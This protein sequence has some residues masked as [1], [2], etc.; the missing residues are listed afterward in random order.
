MKM[1][2]LVALAL[3]LLVALSGLAWRRIKGKAKGVDLVA[4][5]N[6][7]SV[8]SFHYGPATILPKREPTTKASPPAAGN[9]LSKLMPAEDL[10]LQEE[11]A[12]AAAAAGADAAQHAQTEQL[13]QAT[14]QSA[15]PKA[16]DGQE[17][18]TAPLRSSRHAPGAKLNVLDMLAAD[19]LAA[20]E[21]AA[22]E[23]APAHQEEPAVAAA[24]AEPTVPQTLFTNPLTEVTRTKNDEAN[25]KAA[26]ALKQRNRAA[27]R[28]GTDGQK[29]ALAAL[30]TEGTAPG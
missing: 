8:W 22:A 27:L 3:F 15:E 24:A 1:A 10:Q 12:K 16:A 29:A 20:A 30:I 11:Q 21:P 18:P 6:H 7:K 9:P 28:T 23:V 17:A 13:P 26:V 2:L 5:S 19:K 25:R 4:K 14:Q